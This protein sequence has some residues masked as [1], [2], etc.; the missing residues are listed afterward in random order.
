MFLGFIRKY[1]E[2]L[3]KHLEPGIQNAILLQLIDIS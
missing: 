3:I 1:H 2:E